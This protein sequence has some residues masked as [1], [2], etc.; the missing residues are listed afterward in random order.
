MG[1]NWLEKNGKNDPNDQ[2]DNYWH[3]KMTQE[4][5]FGQFPCFRNR[6]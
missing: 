4:P 6:D 1:E 2:N 5:I 3:R